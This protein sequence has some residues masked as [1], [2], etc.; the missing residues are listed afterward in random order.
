[1][2]VSQIINMML[3]GL[4]MHW[5]MWHLRLLTHEHQAIMG[6]MGALSFKIT[7]LHDLQQIL[8]TFA[9]LPLAYDGQGLALDGLALVDIDDAQWRFFYI[10]KALIAERLKAKKLQIHRCDDL[11]TNKILVFTA[12]QVQQNTVLRCEHEI[13]HLKTPILGQQ[14][15]VLVMPIDYKTYLFR[16]KAGRYEVYLKHH[17]TQHLLN[18]P[19]KAKLKV[20]V[21]HDIQLHIGSKKW[22]LLNNKDR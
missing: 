1:M 14:Q 8:L 13:L 7:V 19:D 5:G 4:M 20:T 15:E 9:N 21:D 16:F 18:I 2:G 12:T 6:V 3:L 11:E 22:E 17:D 10:K